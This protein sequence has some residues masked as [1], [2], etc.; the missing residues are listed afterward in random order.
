MAAQKSRNMEILKAMVECADV[1][2]SNR[3]SRRREQRERKEIISEQ[4]MVGNSM[5]FKKGTDPWIQESQ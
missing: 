5:E 3:S 1:T 4:I 2:M